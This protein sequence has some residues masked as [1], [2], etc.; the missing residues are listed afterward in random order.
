M[1]N[2]GGI[3][4][5]HSSITVCKYYGHMMNTL[6]NK[7]RTEVCP[8][9]WIE[10]S[11]N[12]FYRCQSSVYKH[13]DHTTSDINLN[14]NDHVIEKI[15]IFTIPEKGTSNL[16][17]FWKEKEF[18]EEVHEK[19]ELRNTSEPI[20]EFFFLSSKNR[21]IEIQNG[22]YKGK[23]ADKTMTR[24]SHRQILDNRSLFVFNYKNTTREIATAYW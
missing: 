3:G 14:K 4:V 16:T 24:K 1:I 10:W 13:K 11:N 7:Y 19:A 9:R 20:H 21:R 23:P 22:T 18:Q 17:F 12:G 5:R 8:A 2:A 6:I 15:C